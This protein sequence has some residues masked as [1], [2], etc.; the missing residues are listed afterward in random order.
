VWDVFSYG[1]FKRLE[2]LQKIKASQ[3]LRCLGF[4]PDQASDAI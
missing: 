4:A 3:R 1:I 2:C